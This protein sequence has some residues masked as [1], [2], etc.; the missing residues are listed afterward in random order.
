MA[1]YRRREAKYLQRMGVHVPEVA[2]TLLLQEEKFTFYFAQL[3]HLVSCPAHLYASARAA[4]R[5]VVNTALHNDYLML[6]LLGGRR[7]WFGG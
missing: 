7:G 1:L 6:M 4:Q 2:C 5:P 3:S